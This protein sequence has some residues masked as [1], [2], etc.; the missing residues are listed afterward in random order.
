MSINNSSTLVKLGTEEK[1]WEFLPDIIENLSRYLRNG[2]LIELSKAC[3]T[4][5]MQLKK[6]IFKSLTIFRR[7]KTLLD[8]YDE[9]LNR[10]AKL[11]I[12]LKDMTNDLKGS[13]HLVQELKISISIP[14]YFISNLLT[15]FK[16]INR[17]VIFGGGKISLAGLI[18]ILNDL[19]NLKHVK[20]PFIFNHIKN[21][22]MESYLPFFRKME[23]IEI[24]GLWNYEYKP[25][26]SMIFDQSFNNITTLSTSYLDILRSFPTN[27]PNLVQAEIHRYHCSG[28]KLIT[29]IDFLDNNTQL[30][31][32]SIS[33]SLLYTEVV[34]IILNYDRL[35]YLEVT[36]C[37]NY[38][39]LRNI[40][41]ISNQSIQYLKLHQDLETEN[42]KLFLNSCKNLKI[43][44]GY[45]LS[46]LSD[47]DLDLDEDRVFDLLILKNSPYIKNPTLPYSMLNYFKRVKLVNWQD[48]DKFKS[49]ALTNLKDWSLILNNTTKLREYRLIKE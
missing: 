47:F 11:Y 40:E 3:K 42:L 10:K 25:S 49:K 39:P 7:Q 30:Q 14:I 15:L 32:L 18:P 6:E 17:V 33:S 35:K 21:S 38:E 26:S 4:Y 43:V 37:L 23:T 8:S 34:K 13:I 48:I 44:E 29:L 46:Y 20:L 5:R 24:D 2:D 16:D 28:F 41:A 9:S 22:D 27:L 31:K 12:I 1:A 36:G 45:D 19:K